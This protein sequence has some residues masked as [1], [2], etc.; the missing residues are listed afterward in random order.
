MERLFTGLF[1]QKRFWHIP[2]HST[3][4]TRAGRR[5]RRRATFN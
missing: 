5:H 3:S 1:L 2:R 4:S